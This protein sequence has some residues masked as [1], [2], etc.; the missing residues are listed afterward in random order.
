MSSVV[1]DVCFRSRPAC[2]ARKEDIP[3][4]VDHRDDIKVAV[5]REIKFVAEITTAPLLQEAWHVDD[6]TTEH[7][8]PGEDRVASTPVLLHFIRDSAAYLVFLA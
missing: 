8:Y 2:T 7:I 3:V 5:L 4:L 6:T 1:N